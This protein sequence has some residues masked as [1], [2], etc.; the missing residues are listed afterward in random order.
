MAYTFQKEAFGASVQPPPSPNLTRP[1]PDWKPHKITDSLTRHN[2]EIW[3]YKVET[4]FRGKGSEWLFGT[5][6]KEHAWIYDSN[7]AHLQGFITDAQAEEIK[8]AQDASDA[9]NTFQKKGLINQFAGCWNGPKK[10]QW[11]QEAARVSYQLMEILDTYDFD[12]I[13]DLDIKLVGLG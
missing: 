11:E 1:P 7:I 6:L 12:A 10:S 4:Y 13:K 9:Q 5:T 8:K 3:S 2:K